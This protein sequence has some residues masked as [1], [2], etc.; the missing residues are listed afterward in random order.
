MNLTELYNETIALTGRPDLSAQ[1][2][3]AIAAAIM[4]AHTSD[5]FFRDLIEF[6]VEFDA[7]RYIQTFNPKLVLPNYRQ[8]KY[9]RT[10]DGG[11]DGNFGPFFEHIQINNSIDAYGY[12]KNNVYYMAGTFLQ[13]RGMPEVSKIL[14]GA[15]QYPVV[16]SAGFD[17]WIAAEFPWAIIYEAARMIFARIG[18]VEQAAG[19][20]QLVQE[21]Y[22]NLIRYNVDMPPS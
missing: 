10:W 8:V 21:Q 9:I 5:F 22:S 1:T 18:Y 14:F 7:P 16:V 13:I 4:K 3:S 20:R 2:T 12:T 11:F 15:Y 19:I 17:S 6:A